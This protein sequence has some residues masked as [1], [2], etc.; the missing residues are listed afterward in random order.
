MTE[1]QPEARSPSALAVDLLLPDRR[2]QALRQLVA[3]GFIQDHTLGAWTEELRQLRYS[4]GESHILAAATCLDLAQAL[5][6]QGGFLSSSKPQGI[7]QRLIQILTTTGNQSVLQ[8]EH[9]RRR[10]VLDFGAGRY[11]TLA[12]SIVMYANGF[13]RVI[14]LEP[15]PVYTDFARATAMLALQWLH[16]D[17]APLL[18]SGIAKAEMRQRLALL[19]F[20]QLEPRLAALNAGEVDRVDCKGVELVRSMDAVAAGTVDFLFSNSTLEHVPDLGAEVAR[21]HEV[22]AG[23]GLCV[24]T[25]DFSDHRAIGTSMHRFQMY[26]DGVLDEIN[27]LRPFQVESL[28]ARH[29]FDGVRINA[30][31]VPAGYIRNTEG[32]VQPYAGFSVDELS[33]WLRSYVLKKRP[34]S[35]AT[36]APGPA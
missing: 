34:S 19:D 36:P 16:L 30:L 24:H 20:E 13:D 4:M 10:T 25:V 15:M 9:L 2:E 31:D 12:L 27:G 1:I 29:G 6:A 21:H 17:P 18:F 28:F 32:M 26:Y 8:R 33:A 14:A 23:G 11:S 7:L 5:E 3:R 35:A 22:L